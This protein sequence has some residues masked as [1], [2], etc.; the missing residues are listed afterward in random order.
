MA[1]VL[2]FEN[3]ASTI[4]ENLPLVHTLN[5]PITV[6]EDDTAESLAAAMAEEEFPVIYFYMYDAEREAWNEN[7][8]NVSNCLH[9]FVTNTTTEGE[10]QDAVDTVHAS[11]TYVRPMELAKVSIDFDD[12]DD[13][14]FDP[15]KSLGCYVIY[16]PTDHSDYNYINELDGTAFDESLIAKNAPW[17]LEEAE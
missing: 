10:G 17:I 2:D 5:L 8:V 3:A 7:P 6:G 13:L 4:D 12:A 14:F 15:Y 1:Y 16:N 11:F 9:L